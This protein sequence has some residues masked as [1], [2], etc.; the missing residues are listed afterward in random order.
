MALN[1]KEDDAS[2]CPSRPKV[3]LQL[4]PQIRYFEKQDHRRKMATQTYERFSA[5]QVTDSM[6]TA[7]AQLF[8]ENYGIWGR[9]GAKPG[10]RAILFRRSLLNIHTKA[11]HRREG[12]AR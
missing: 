7:A 11:L 5:E 6:L 9:D 4:E 3:T 1:K 8:S 10:E 2:D 12:E